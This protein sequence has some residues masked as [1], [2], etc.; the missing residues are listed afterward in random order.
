LNE[1]VEPVQL[2]VFSTAA[3]QDE[4]ERKFFASS[5]KVFPRLKRKGSRLSSAASAGSGHSV[6]SAASLSSMGS[7]N[8]M[9][10]DVATVGSAIAE[11]DEATDYV[12]RIVSTFR[13]ENLRQ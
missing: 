9:D 7:V 6:S 11:E 5:G 12:F 8:S 3:L 10:V 4:G 2:T 13:P 1:Y